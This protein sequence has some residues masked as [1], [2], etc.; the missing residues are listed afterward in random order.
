MVFEKYLNLIISNDLF[1]FTQK[2]TDA[3]NGNKTKLTWT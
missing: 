2:I 3:E 1:N